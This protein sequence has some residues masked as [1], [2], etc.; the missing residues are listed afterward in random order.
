MTSLY[1]DTQLLLAVDLREDDSSLDAALASLSG[2][3]ITQLALKAKAKAYQAR[4]DRGLAAAANRGASL[5]ELAAAAGMAPDEVLV[6][7]RSTLR[8]L[9]EPA[10]RVR[11]GLDATRT[12]PRTAAR[13]AADAG[14]ESGRKQRR[15]WRR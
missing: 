1:D 11:L 8:G 4:I 13:P 9:V 15:W 10:T 6:R 12:D 3:V 7:L 2:A 14:A 5:D